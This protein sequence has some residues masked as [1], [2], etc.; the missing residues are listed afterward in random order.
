MHGSLFG[1]LYEALRVYYLSNVSRLL[2]V[3]LFTTGTSQIVITSVV[4]Q[5]Y[6]VY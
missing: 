3:I 5:F 6:H 1:S 2:K 4:C